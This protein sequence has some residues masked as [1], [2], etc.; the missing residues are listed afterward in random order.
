MKTL[1]IAAVLALSTVAAPASAQTQNPQNMADMQCFASIA[2]LAG[3]SEADAIQIA[4]L[5]AG[6]MYYLGRLEGRSPNVD[7]LQQLHIY[8]NATDEAEI[9]SHLSRCGTELSAK[10]DALVAWGEAMAGE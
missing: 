1:M 5:T 2:Y 4:G 8:L 7:W 9:Q 10:G 3:K 6:T